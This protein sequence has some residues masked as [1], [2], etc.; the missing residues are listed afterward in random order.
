MYS[1]GWLNGRYHGFGHLTLKEGEG[2]YEGQFRN[3]ERHGQGKQVDA[4][5]SVYT[6]DWRDDTQWGSATIVYPTSAVYTGQ[7]LSLYLII[8]F[9]L[10]ISHRSTPMS[11]L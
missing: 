10:I 11:V 5:G 6:G 2:S 3:G 1:G 8:S 4:D 9:P 7:P